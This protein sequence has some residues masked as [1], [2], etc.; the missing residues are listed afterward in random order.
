MPRAR[1]GVDAPRRSHDRP[2]T[3]RCEHCGVEGYDADADPDSFTTALRV[4]TAKYLAI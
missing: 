1:V 4:H 2:D 3:A